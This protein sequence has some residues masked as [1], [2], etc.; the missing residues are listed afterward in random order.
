[1][2]RPP[3]RGHH[4]VPAI[5]IAPHVGSRCQLEQAGKVVVMNAQ[6]RRHRSSSL[7][8]QHEQP[9][10]RSDR[11]QHFRKPRLERLVAAVHGYRGIDIASDV[12]HRQVIHTTIYVEI[13]DRSGHD[14]GFIEARP[15]ER[16]EIGFERRAVPVATDETPM[17]G[18]RRSKR[19]AAHSTRP[20]I[21]SW[22]EG[23]SGLTELSRFDGCPAVKRICQLPSYWIDAAGQA[24]NPTASSRLTILQ[25]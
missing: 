10:G 24:L 5:T 9:A 15:T 1:M 21:P 20:S 8:L 23:S 19:R 25:D 13:V 16:I 14:D 4:H 2:S 6:R 3:E 22:S 7:V 12:T 11:V 17:D 18:R